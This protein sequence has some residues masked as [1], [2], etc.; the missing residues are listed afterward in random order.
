MCDIMERRINEEKTELAK[1]AINA[2]KFS[3]KEIAEILRL[4]LEFVEN[5]ADTKQAPA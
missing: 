5:L 2:G 1:D 4:P 3:P